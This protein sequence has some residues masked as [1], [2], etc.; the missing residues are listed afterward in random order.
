[1]AERA[2]TLAAALVTAIAGWE[3]LPEGMPVLRVR[4]VTQ[5]IKDLSDDSPAV[6]CVIHHVAEDGSGRAD[7][8]DDLT[9]GIV[10]I[11]RCASNAVADSDAWAELTESLRDW[12]RTST[13]FKNISLG[14]GL[15]AQRKQIETTVVCDAQMLDEK[16]VF[17]SVTEGMWFVSVGNRS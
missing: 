2:K 8:S 5:L 11:A 15:A 16:E 13:T 12:I 10:V 6:I 17:V 4:S 1:M 14:D 9:F 7:V 3:L